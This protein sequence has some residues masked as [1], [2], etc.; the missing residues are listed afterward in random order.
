V[1][2]SVRTLLSRIMLVLGLL[3][4]ASGG[5]VLVWAR[6][7]PHGYIEMVFAVPLLSLGG[8]SDSVFT[9]V[10]AA[11]DAQG[12][13]DCIAITPPAVAVASGVCVISSPVALAAERVIASDASWQIAER[14]W[15]SDARL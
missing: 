2:P 4:A 8:G 15:H 7:S 6:P 9:S 11:G 14:A 3:L 1:A 10:D 12:T 5:Y 13:S